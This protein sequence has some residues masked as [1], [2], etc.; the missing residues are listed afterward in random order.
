MAS[1]EEC[2]GVDVLDFLSDRNIS[3]VF[4]GSGS[5]WN[6]IKSGVPQGS[7]LGPGTVLYLYV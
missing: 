6:T 2:Y 5:T 4:D 3:V 1:L 7:V